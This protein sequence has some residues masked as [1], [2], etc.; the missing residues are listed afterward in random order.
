M[1]CDIKGNIYVTR[2]GKGTIVVLSPEG[3]II[4]E[5][6][7]KGKNHQILHSADTMVEQ[8]M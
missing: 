4:N 7:L 1:R 8:Y 6:E 5:I 3:K 2:H